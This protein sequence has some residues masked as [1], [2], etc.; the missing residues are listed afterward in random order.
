MLVS[1][2]CDGLPPEVGEA[3]VTMAP[4]VRQRAIVA[5]LERGAF[6]LYMVPS[7]E[8]RAAWELGLQGAHNER[9]ARVEG[10]LRWW[11]DSVTCSTVARTRACVIGVA[12][13]P[14]F[15]LGQHFS[16]KLKRNGDSLA[17]VTGRLFTE[18]AF[19]TYA[20]AHHPSSVG[21]AIARLAVKHDCFAR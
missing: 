4:P 19:S 16:A 17:F 7:A 13:S 2:V 1:V 6:V 20:E 21:D 15:V 14:I 3:L 11:V 8:Q 5:A 18:T 10:T 9:I 12:N